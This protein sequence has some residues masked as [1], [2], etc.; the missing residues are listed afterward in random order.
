MPMRS[1]GGRPV[2]L[3]LC[4]HHYRVSRTALAKAQAVVYDGETPPVPV[5]P[6]NP[7]VGRR[8][9]RAG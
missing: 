6:A 1:A 7:G 5:A 8:W 4:G 3:F 9:T 2:E